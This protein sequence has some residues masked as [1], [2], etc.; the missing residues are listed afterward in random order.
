M[1]LYW[2]DEV[3]SMPEWT[4]ASDRQRW[5]EL[6]IPDHW[7]VYAIFGKSLPTLYIGFT[8]NVARRLT[9]H[10]KLK[11]WWPAVDHI[12]IG[13]A[14]SESEAREWEKRYIRR[15]QPIYNIAGVW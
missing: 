11:P 14:D 12:I 10:S 8:G 4:N 1:T 5:R 7:F 13:L 6:S 2:D 15:V 3:G 9:Q